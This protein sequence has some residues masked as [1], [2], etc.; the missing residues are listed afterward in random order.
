LLRRLV[1]L[2]QFET[3]AAHVPRRRGEQITGSERTELFDWAGV[4]L[5]IPLIAKNAMNGALNL[6]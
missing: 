6:V 4:E 3:A 5:A 2:G 1:Q